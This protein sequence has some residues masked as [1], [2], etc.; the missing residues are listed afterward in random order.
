M[1]DITIKN[2]TEIIK[3]DLKER[4]QEAVAHFLNSIDTA[5]TT[6]EAYQKGIKKFLIYLDT[7]NIEAPTEADIIN[8]KK[9]LIKNNEAPSVNLYITALRK[10][11]KYLAKHNIADDITEDLKGIKQNREHKKTGLNIDQAKDLIASTNDKRDKAIILLLLTGAL[12]TIE[13]ERA[14]V[15]D[16]TTKGNNYILRVQ[17]KGHQKKDD[18]IILTKNTYKAINEYLATRKNIKPSDALFTSDSNR[19]N[20][21]RLKTRSIRHIIKA[22]LKDIGINTPTITTHSLRHTAITQAILNGADL[23]QAQQLARHK[24]PDTTTI[25]IDEI[26]TEKAKEKATAILESVYI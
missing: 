13:L 10:F 8:Y 14:N 20:G 7:N 2:N 26:A 1:N 11:Y 19:T 17:G 18:F 9:Y 4:R 22:H 5:D 25:Y 21:E 24:N 6:K 15:E 23:M 16:I 3:D 12:R